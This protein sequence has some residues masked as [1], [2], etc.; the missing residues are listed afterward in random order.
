MGYL[1]LIYLFIGLI[2]AIRRADAE[3]GMVVARDPVLFGMTI[4]LWPLILWFK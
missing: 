3:S 2:I 1:I 4:I